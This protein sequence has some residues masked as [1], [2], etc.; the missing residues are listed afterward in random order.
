MAWRAHREVPIV[1][2][3]TPPVPIE[4]AV[5]L[6]RDQVDRIVRESG[7]PERARGFD[8]AVWLSRWLE[9][10]VP[11]LGGRRPVDYLGSA[12][13]V[14]LVSALLASMQASAYW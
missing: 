3:M 11:A 12:E 6:L 10:P 5:D 7:D 4:R 8:S 1:S 13:G 14:E 2:R 9:A